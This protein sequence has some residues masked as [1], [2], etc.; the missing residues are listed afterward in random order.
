MGAKRCQQNISTSCKKEILKPIIIAPLNF[1]F[2]VWTH[3][4]F[5]TLTG[6]EELDMTIGAKKG[7]SWTTE[8]R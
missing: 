3:N 8:S 7:A 5:Y 6:N 4:G 1:K 2:K